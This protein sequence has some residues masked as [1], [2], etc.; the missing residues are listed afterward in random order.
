MYC[1]SHGSHNSISPFYLAVHIT[2]LEFGIRVLPG[3]KNNYAMGTAEEPFSNPF[4]EECSI[5]KCQQNLVKELGSAQVDT[6]IV[7]CMGHYF[8]IGQLNFRG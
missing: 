8:I 7:F 1:A 4:F 5:K 6:E 3:T 2:L